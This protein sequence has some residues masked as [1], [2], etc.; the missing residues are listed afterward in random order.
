M[1]KR[2]KYLVPV[3]ALGG[4]FTESYFESALT[5]D[6]DFIAIDSGST[7]GGP[8][9]LG[10][11]S[12]LMSRSAMKRDLK[13]ILRGTRALGIPLLVGSSGGSGGN[14]NLDGV[15]EILREIAEEDGHHFNVALIYSEP[16][17]E[18]L[19]G[20]LTEGKVHPL[21][22]APPIDDSVLKKTHRIVA[23][24][25]PE[26]FIEALNNGADVVLAGRSSDAALMAAFPLKEGLNP[27]PAWH[28][29]KIM[30]CGGA[31]V[32]QM[33]KPEGM[34]C[35][36]TDEYFELEP[37]SPLQS[38][39]PLSVASH[40][41]YETSNPVRMV[42]PGGIMNL[43]H[44]RYEA[45]NDRIVRVWGSKFESMPYTVKLEGADIVGYRSAS[46]GGVTDPAILE[47]F[48]TWFE[49]AKSGAEA[50]LR[51][52]QGDLL[53]DQCEVTYR[54][55]GRDAVLNHS[56]ETTG[57]E[58]G[59]LIDVLAP[60]QELASSA[61]KTLSHT[62]LHHPVPQWHG[63]VSNLAFPFSPHD[64]DLGATYSFVLNHVV[65]LEDP[66]ELYTLKYQEV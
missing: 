27:G 16:D 5:Q 45:V 49:Q 51:R 11:D 28:A 7:D 47:D 53:A 65:E 66:L 9:A 58:V 21:N 19:V 31:A 15:Y 50:N 62:I 10:A 63:L 25:G 17:R 40:A 24:M 57:H 37:V 12:F 64:F 6:L 44:V 13:I 61:A 56:L 42:E 43:E 26:P 48:D 14:K 30:E 33:T 20:K 34:I 46:L 35:T 36:L 3:G 22:P 2:I 60:S 23:M 18:T 4:G 52:S 59:V 32:T 29:A 55:Y 8:N 54:V 38:C 1:S 41:L 39:T